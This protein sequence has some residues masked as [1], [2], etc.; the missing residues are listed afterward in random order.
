MM[1][2]YKDH[3]FREN[4]LRSYLGKYDN[5]FKL[6]KIEENNIILCTNTRPLIIA[7]YHHVWVSLSEYLQIEEDDPYFGSFDHYQIPV[8]TVPIEDP[9]GM[10]KIE[11]AI[12]KLFLSGSSH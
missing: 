10:A 5:R 4:L 8:A 3:I 11:K 7:Q 6:L 2:N 1:N 12:G 9:N